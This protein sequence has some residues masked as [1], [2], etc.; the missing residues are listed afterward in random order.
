MRRTSS[1]DSVDNPECAT[2]ST[3]TPSNRNTTQWVPSQT[4]TARCAIVSK[5]G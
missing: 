4:R 3:S 1:T 2:A 5:T